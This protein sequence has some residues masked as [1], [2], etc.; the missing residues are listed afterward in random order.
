MLALKSQQYCSCWAIPCLKLNIQEILSNPEGK[1][2]LISAVHVT[3]VESGIS[4][5]CWLPYDSVWCEWKSKTGPLL[6]MGICGGQ[7]LEATSDR[8][9]PVLKSRENELVYVG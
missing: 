6:V 9:T 3:V 7:P 8:F 5:I 1:T 4:V 2:V